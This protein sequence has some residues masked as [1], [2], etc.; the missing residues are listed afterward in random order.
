MA[1]ISQFFADCNAGT[2]PAVSFVDSEIGLLNVLGTDLANQ[3]PIGNGVA[4]YSAA[5]DQ[6]EENP[7]DIQVGESFVQSVVDAVLASPAWPRTLLIFTYD[8]HGGYYDHVPP[9]PAIA[10]DAIKPQ[11]GP[12]DYPGGYDSYGV[13]VPTVVASPFSKAH[14]V[15]NVVCDHTSVLATI[16]A[17]WNLPACTYRDANANTVASFLDTSEPALL[18]PPML[19]D[20]GSLA[21]GETNCDTS[22]PKLKV[23]PAPKVTRAGRLIV[24]YD[25]PIEGF[26]GVE[27]RL[28]TRTGTLQGVEIELVRHGHTIVRVH[29]GRVTTHRTILTMR[30]PHRLTAGRYTIVVRRHGRTLVRRSIR[31]DRAAKRGASR[32]SRA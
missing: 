22:D 10:P 7:A 20:S 4:N 18:D 21:P 5:Q 32:P 19:A 25:G 28:R 26:D 9:P 24:S 1:P 16:E 31:I 2:L 3:I 12:H 11:L 6:D 17:K 23:L 27:V 30:S 15:S 8:E 14:G 13:R 29:V